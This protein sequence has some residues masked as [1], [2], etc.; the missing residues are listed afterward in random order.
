MF[1]RLATHDTRA[2]AVARNR[3]HRNALERQLEAG[4]GPAVFGEPVEPVEPKLVLAGNI[5]RAGHISESHSPFSRSKIAA[6]VT[7]ICWLTLVPKADTQL[8]C[9]LPQRAFSS[10]HLLCNFGNR[11][12]CLRMPSQLREQRLSPTHSLRYSLRHL[13]TPLSRR[14]KPIRSNT[15]Q[16]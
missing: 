2:F 16:R 3:R 10:F 11:R 15:L 9:L 5:A 6:T 13:H 8:Q 4:R 1:Q 14:Y 7:G 12:S